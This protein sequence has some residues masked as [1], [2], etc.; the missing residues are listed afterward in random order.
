MYTIHVRKAET[1]T[2]TSEYTIRVS[3]ADTAKATS[4]YTIHASK[5]D[6]ATATSDYTIRVSTPKEKQLL[7][8][9]F[10]LVLFT[11]VVGVAVV[12]T[13]QN[14]DAPELD[15][16]R[17]TLSFMHAS[18]LINTHFY[19]HLD[20]HVAPPADSFCMYAVQVRPLHGVNIA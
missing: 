20:H 13:L 17:R 2:A 16:T 18:S 1:A 12:D 6:T 3:K 7:P 10:V 19:I 11:V 14:F 8:L 5:A 15:G 4:D 9:L